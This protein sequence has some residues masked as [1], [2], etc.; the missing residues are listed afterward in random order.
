MKTIKNIRTG[1]IKRVTD[2]DVDDKL[3]IYSKI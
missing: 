2:K 1:E 3:K